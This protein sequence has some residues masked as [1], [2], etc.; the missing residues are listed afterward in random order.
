MSLQNRYC[1]LFPF[2]ENLVELKNN[3]GQDI[4]INASWL[5]LP[6]GTGRYIVQRMLSIGGVENGEGAFGFA[7]Y[8]GGGGK[9]GTLFM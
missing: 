5:E 4:Y 8:W 9:S 2:D 1:N 6:K 3:D 7:Y